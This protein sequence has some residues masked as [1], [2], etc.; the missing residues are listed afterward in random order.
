MNRRDYLRTI[1]LASAGAG[2]MPSVKAM[3]QSQ[4]DKY[5]GWTGRQFKATGFF[6][7]EQDDRWWLVTPEGNAFLSFGINHIHPNFW[8]EQHNASA[9]QKVFG[10]ENIWDVRQFYPALRKWVIEGCAD[11]G[12]NTLGVHTSLQVLN[13]PRPEIPYMQPFRVLDIPHW[14]DEITD[15]KFEDV[16]APDFERKCERTAGNLCASLRDD[17]YLLGYSMTDCP[18]FTEEDLRERTDVIGGK[19]RAKR[20]IGFPRRL[21]NLGANA[22][23]K[24]VYVTLMHE[25]YAGSIDRFNETY[26][27]AFDT[28][29]ALASAGNWRPE[30]DLS[31]ANETRDNTR[32][33]LAVVDR[34][35]KCA[36]KAIRRHDPNHLFV[37]DKINANTDCADTIIRT[38]TRYTD[39]FFY[40]YYSRYEVQKFAMDRWSKILDQPMINGDSAYTQVT[41]AMPHP[42]GP[43]ATGVEERIQWT[44]TF[45]REAFARP[46]FVGWHYCG[47]VDGDNKMNVPGREYRQHSGMIDSLGSPY[48]GGKENLQRCVEQMYDIASGGVS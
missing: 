39:I 9:W 29:D 16:F 1:L 3:I 18:L 28:F 48:P 24:K 15:D 5:G 32:F 40:Q 46:D 41:P 37:G 34:Y 31:N 20:S 11:Y 25:L 45:F 23:G 27:T 43:I 21:R 36:S 7:L 19:R 14:H 8:R 44:N 42:F 22:P 30:T 17:P 47:W 13:N 10:L 2:M 35:Y 26:G 6:R 12:F 4:Y 33:L 38:T